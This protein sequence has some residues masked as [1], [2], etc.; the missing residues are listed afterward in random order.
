L[1]IN[2]VFSIVEEANTET[3]SAKRVVNE[4]AKKVSALSERVQA[5]DNFNERNIKEQIANGL[6]SN[7]DFFEKT[8]KPNVFSLVE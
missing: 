6:F 4:F 2:N 8:I 3:N 5:V 1:R 7:I